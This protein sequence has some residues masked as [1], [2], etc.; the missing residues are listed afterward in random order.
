M[1]S[2]MV[3]RQNSVVNSATK[4]N[5][6][7]LDPTSYNVGDSKFMFTLYSQTFNSSFYKILD[8]SYFTFNITQF[9]DTKSGT[10]I[11]QASRILTSIDYGY[12]DDRFKDV[13]GSSISQAIPFN[14]T[15]CPKTT[16]LI[17]GGNYLATEFNF[18]QIELRKC[19][20]Q[21]Y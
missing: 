13:L 15:I 20:K 4:M 1:I 21:S 18:F 11:D 12:C 16:D 5:S 6:L 10:G 17:V 9:K 14:F 3:N 2:E 7:I 19:T 8:P